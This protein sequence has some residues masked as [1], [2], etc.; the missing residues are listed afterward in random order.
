MFS[1]LLV[2][3]S[4]NSIPIIGIELLQSGDVKASRPLSPKRLE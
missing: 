3:L 4:F 2:A 1:L